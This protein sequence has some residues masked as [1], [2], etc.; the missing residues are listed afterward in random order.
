MIHF[1]LTIGT[2]KI[3]EIIGTMK[4]LVITG[5]IIMVKTMMEMAL[6]IHLMTMVW[7]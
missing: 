6:V 1:G 4:E 2:M 3:L 5:R 7:A